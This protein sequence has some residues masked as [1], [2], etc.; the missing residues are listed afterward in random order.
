MI[1]SLC[2]T[3]FVSG[4]ES[5]SFFFW[6]SQE[7]FESRQLDQESNFLSL[8]QTV[9]ISYFIKAINSLLL[10]VYRRNKPR[11]MLG[12]HSCFLVFSNIMAPVKTEE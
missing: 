2:S 12:E 4:T 8:R 5:V 9:S 1:S 3:D 6:S 10:W 11:G 7:F